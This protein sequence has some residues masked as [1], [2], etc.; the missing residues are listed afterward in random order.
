[1]IKLKS[2][3]GRL[4]KLRP[5]SFTRLLLQKQIR[6]NT[7]ENLFLVC[8]A[9]RRNGKLVCYGGS[10]RVLVSLAEVVLV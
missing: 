8:A 5:E 1:M 2:F 4:V 7:L 3:I 9:I 6:K 10:H